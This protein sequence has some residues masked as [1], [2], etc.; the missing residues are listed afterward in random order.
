M[1]VS[2]SCERNDSGAGKTTMMDVLSG[3]I[4]ASSGSYTMNGATATRF[5]V[6]W[7][8]PCLSRWGVERW[9]W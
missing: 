6:N 2:P 7:V 1:C 4:N 3:R 8:S 9:R 5:V